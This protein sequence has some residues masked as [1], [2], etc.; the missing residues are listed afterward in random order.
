MEYSSINRT[1][2][3]TLTDN[4]KIS[5]ESAPCKWTHKIFTSYEGR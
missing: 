2:F 4:K 1:R 5:S 3:K